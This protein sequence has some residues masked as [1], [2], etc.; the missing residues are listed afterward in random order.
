MST[1]FSGVTL[2]HIVSGGSTSHSP[3]LRWP[4]C[5]MWRNKTRK[6]LLARRAFS[7]SPSPPARHGRPPPRPTTESGL[8]FASE[9]MTMRTQL[10]CAIQARLALQGSYGKLRLIFPEQMRT[11]QCTL[12]SWWL[13]K[14]RFCIPR[15]RCKPHCAH[16]FSVGETNVLH[17]QNEMRT[18]WCTL[19]LCWRNLGFHS[20]N[21][22]RTLWR[23]LI[24]GKGNLAFA[25]PER[26]A[27]PMLRTQFWV[28]ES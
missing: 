20:Q 19:I 21:E 27:I 13:A 1:P 26:D 15:T 23:T 4:S 5:L 22:I 25:L 12:I 7:T 14:A 9:A 24:L 2:S 16:S 17:S 3:H 8:W 28:G 6:L 10:V 11:I 18:L